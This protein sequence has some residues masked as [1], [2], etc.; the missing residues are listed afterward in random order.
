[1]LPTRRTFL[2]TREQPRPEPP[3]LRLLL[4]ERPFS[5]LVS[6]SRR[7]CALEPPRPRKEHEAAEPAFTDLFG[8]TD[9]ALQRMMEEDLAGIP[10]DELIRQFREAYAV[11]DG[12]KLT[13]EALDV[14]TYTVLILLR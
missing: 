4:C 3:T 1:L 6:T 2:P 7:E 8:T 12:F 10:R 9:E 13:T 5:G 11:L 14:A